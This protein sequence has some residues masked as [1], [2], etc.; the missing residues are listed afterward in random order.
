MDRFAASFELKRWLEAG[1][2]VIL[3]RYVSSNM[4][5]QGGKMRDPEEREEFFRWDTELEYD[6]LELPRPDLNILLYVPAEVSQELALRK[7]DWKSNKVKTLQRK[8]IHEGSLE[9]LKGAEES[10]LQM[11]RML[12]GWVRIDCT[13]QGRM[14][15]RN[16]IHKKVLEE[17]LKAISS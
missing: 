15:S 9:H 10:Y 3:D 7:W 16:I 17:T 13:E 4:G 1:H 14:L 2:I 12:P 8:D 6:I 5:H 11:A